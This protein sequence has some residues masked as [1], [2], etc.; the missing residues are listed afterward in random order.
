MRRCNFSRFLMVL[1]AIMLVVGGLAG[2]TGGRKTKVGLSFSDFENERWRMEDAMLRRLLEEKGYEV[3]STVA[4]HNVDLQKEQINSMIDQGVKA[5]FIVAQDGEAVIPLVD[6]AAEAGILVI[7]YDRL[8]RSSNIAAY[9]SFNNIEVGRQQAMGVLQALDMENWDVASKGKARIVLLGGSETDNNA[10]LF[11]K[12]QLEILGQY[13]DKIEIV[14]DPWVEKWLAENAQKLMEEILT[15]QKDDIDAVVAS[16]DNTALGALNALREH[17]LAGKIPISGQDATINGCNSIAKGELT[18][19]VF[20]DVRNLA[21]LSV[22]LVVKLLE[23]QQISDLKTYS[24]DE[25]TNGAVKTGSVPCLF[26]PV[27]QLNKD[28]L[29]ELIVKSQF[30][31]YDEVYQGIPEDQLPPR[32]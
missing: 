13:E 29:Y 8:I 5:L 21:P 25:L 27:F 28:N 2:C 3:I 19:S 23:G 22:D 18:V 15:E 9:I 6:R 4:D 30:H 32:P 20:K 24:L 17:G 12:G 14:A 10:I 1:T 16:N 11:R 26:L 7:A 31:S